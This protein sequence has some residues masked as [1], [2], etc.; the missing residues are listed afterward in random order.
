L[1]GAVL[2]YTV[3]MAQ[4][5]N[6]FDLAKQVT[7]WRSGSDED[8]QVAHELVELDRTRHGL[9]FAHLALEKML[10][11]HVCRATL[12]LAPKIHNLLRLAEL[13]QVPVSA[14]QRSFLGRFNQYQLE[15]R[16]PDSVEYPLSKKRANN[17]LVKAGEMLKWLKILL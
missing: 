5:E 13:A 6:E 7:Y 2:G 15:G 4:T 14:E 9:F 17:E 12:A 11:A 1:L 3:T 16:Y 10:K 8:I